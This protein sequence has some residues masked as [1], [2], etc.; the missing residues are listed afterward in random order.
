MKEI[1]LRSQAQTVSAS[2]CCL[3]LLGCLLVSF[4]GA[5]GQQRRAQRQPA[6]AG[7]QQA[8]TEGHPAT[9]P[10]FD[11]L[12]ADASAA[13]EGD[14]IDEAIALYRKALALRPQWAEGWWYLSTLYYDHDNYPEAARGFKEAAQL[15]KKAGSPWVMLG[16]CE[17][18]LARYDDAY[19]HIQ[20]GR[21]LGIGDNAEL[22]RVMRY[23]EGL[24]RLV[25]GEF[26]RAQQT[27]GIL[28][29]EGLNSEDLIIALGLSVLRM[30]MLPKQVDIN[31]RD[32]E[33]VRRAGLA[34]H[35]NAQKDISDATREYELLAKDFPKFPNVQYAYGRFLLA[36]RDNERAVAAFQHEL[37]NSPKHALA[38]LQIAYI[39]LLN[40]EA[41]EGVPLAEEGVRLHQRLPLGH[42]IL[43][44]LLF[45]AG[46]N[47]RAI[48]ELEL[49]KSLRPDEPKVYFALSRAY[50]KANRKADAEHAREIFTRLSQQG[51][52]AAGGGDVRGDA[53][54]DDNPATEKPSPP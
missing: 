12:A 20:Q 7:Q 31:Y 9:L 1:Y 36:S 34:E 42:Y 25:K 16:L 24:L 50:A 53:L 38:R 5:L 27:L 15:Q 43:G 22:N 52:Q 51:D 40:K 11:K 23:H 8:G 47:A 13:R 28:S 4:L 44:R 37:E 30:G 19:S 35:F 10:D 3:G 21:E 6:S 33:V 32:R 45:D 2:L 46:Q 26:E 48:E 29:Y 17:F 54:P 39:K 49:A 18:Q 14:R 41:V